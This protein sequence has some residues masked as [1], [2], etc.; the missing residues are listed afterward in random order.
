MEAKEAHE[1][2]NLNAEIDTLLEMASQRVLYTDL[3][4]NLALHRKIGSAL[5]KWRSEGI[6]RIHPQEV[7]TLT[8]YQLQ[9]LT[10]MDQQREE[11]AE[12]LIEQ[13]VEQV[14]TTR[15]QV[16]GLPPISFEGF[17]R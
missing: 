13:V 14:A 7:E 3:E 15:E 2:K 17:K 1:I 10:R 8:I 16:F 12:N 4:D 6:V 5:F 9:L 11:R